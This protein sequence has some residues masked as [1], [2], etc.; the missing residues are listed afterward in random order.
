MIACEVYVFIWA[1]RAV[2]VITYTILELLAE[3][4]LIIWNGGTG[5]RIAGEEA[6][7]FKRDIRSG[8]DV[9]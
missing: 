5:A 2:S 1:L 6:F 3:R 8:I 9:L 7:A 4:I